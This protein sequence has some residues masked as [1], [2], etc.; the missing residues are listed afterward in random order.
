MNAT[1][2]NSSHVEPVLP[3]AAEISSLAA[4]LG[5]QWPNLRKRLLTW[6]G[7]FAAVVLLNV[8]VGGIRDLRMFDVVFIPSVSVLVIVSITIGFLWGTALTLHRC[9]RL[10][11]T[12]ARE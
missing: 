6:S 7:V 4:V 12:A 11:H 8:L 3:S 5:T 2:P 9:R 10:T 1:S